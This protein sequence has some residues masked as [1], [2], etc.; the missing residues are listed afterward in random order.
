METLPQ[1][2]V[3]VLRFNNFNGTMMLVAPKTEHPFPKLQVLDI[4]RNPFSGSL[5]E[6]FF[7]NFQGMIDAEENKTVDGTDWFKKLTELRFILKG[8]DQSLQRL[9]V[10][11]CWIPLQQLTYHPIGFMG[12]FHIS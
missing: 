7:N 2:R 6:A 10:T 9:L 3:V 1:L 4:S 12:V 11:L 5:P 8:L